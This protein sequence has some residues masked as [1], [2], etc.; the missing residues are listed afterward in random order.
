M[1]AKL[2][3]YSNNSDLIVEIL[4]MKTTIMNQTETKFITGVV[5]TLSELKPENGRFYGNES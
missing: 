1:S 3:Y 4:S 2:V 5:A